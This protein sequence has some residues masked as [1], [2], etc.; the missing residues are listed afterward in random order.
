VRTAEN[1]LR[2][3][4]APRA[5]KNPRPGVR[6]DLD[7]CVVNPPHGFRS[8]GRAR[9]WKGG[10]AGPWFVIASEDPRPDGGLR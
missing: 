8:L 5:L 2:L 7:G 10:I 1:P 6:R 9:L 3:V 4:T